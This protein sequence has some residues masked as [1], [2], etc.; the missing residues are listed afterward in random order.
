MLQR[1]VRPSRLIGMSCM[2]A[3][4]T[5]VLWIAPSTV[6]A[7]SVHSVEAERGSSV[8][9]AAG[10]FVPVAASRIVDSREGVQVRGPVPGLGW[11]GCG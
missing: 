5:A 7:V 1:L 11:S 9:P 2:V 3:A 6:H 10:V 4:V 8:A